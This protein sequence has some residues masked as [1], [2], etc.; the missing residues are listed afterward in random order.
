MKTNLPSPKTRRW[1]KSRK[2]LVIAAIKRGEITPE[3]AMADYMLSPEELNSW[4]VLFDSFGIGGLRA[5]RVQ[6]Y[7]QELREAA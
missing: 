5:T 1:V 2:Y 6:E 3:K 7:C 4:I